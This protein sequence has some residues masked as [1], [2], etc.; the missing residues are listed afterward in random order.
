MKS[1]KTIARIGY[2]RING[3]KV[4]KGLHAKPWDSWYIMRDNTIVGIAGEYYGDEFVP[5]SDC[6]ILEVHTAE[7]EIVMHMK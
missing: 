5:A 6:E 1:F 2:Y 4:V 7:I 3:L